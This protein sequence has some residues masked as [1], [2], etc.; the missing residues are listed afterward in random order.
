MNIEDTFFLSPGEGFKKSVE[1]HAFVTAGSDA[2]ITHAQT[3][4]HFTKDMS[5]SHVSQEGYNKKIDL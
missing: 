3:Q 2:A 5:F 1:Q 4:G